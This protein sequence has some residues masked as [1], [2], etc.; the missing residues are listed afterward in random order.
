MIEVGDPLPDLGLTITD[1]VTGL[2]ADG[3]AVSLSITLPDQT[4]V[5]SPAPLTV[6]H[7]ATGSYSSSYV[8]TQPGQHKVV[9]TVTGAN[10]GVY[11]DWPYVDNQQGIVSLAEARQ[12]LRLARTNDDEIIRTLILAASSACESPEGTNTVWRRT[13]VTSE[14]HSSD[15]GPGSIQLFRTPVLAIT[16]VVVDGSLW[17][18]TD[19]DLNK[20]SGRLYAVNGYFPGNRRNNVVVSY[21]AGSA[22]VPALVRDGVLEMVRHLYATHRGGSGIPRQEEPD[23]TQQAGY[24]I[25]NRVAMAWRAFEGTGLG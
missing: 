7:P 6:Q 22:T 23:Y 1:P 4:T 10:A 9:W 18:A 17:S 8:T 20:S 2:P 24:L 14:E 13:A 5:S 15:E 12:H 3:G 25:P 16:Q 21:I 11:E 19:Y